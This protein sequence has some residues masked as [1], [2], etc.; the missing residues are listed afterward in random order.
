MIALPPWAAGK[1]TGATTSFGM[2]VWKQNVAVWW[3]GGV[4]A[5]AYRYGVGQ[6]RRPPPRG[7]EAGGVSPEGGLL[8]R[9]GGRAIPHR[10]ARLPPWLGVAAPILRACFLIGGR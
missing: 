2:G 9:A 10:P 6:W 8:G 5:E 1:N 4:G 3:G 7:L